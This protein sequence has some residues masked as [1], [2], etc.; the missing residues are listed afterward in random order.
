MLE[1]IVKLIRMNVIQVRAGTWRSAQPKAHPSDQM[2]SNVLASPVTKVN[3]VE[4]ILTSVNLPLVII[5]AHAHQVL[6]R[7]LVSVYLD[8]LKV[9]SASRKLTSAHLCR[10]N[11]L[12]RAMTSLTSLSVSVRLD[13]AEIDVKLIW[14]SVPIS[15]VRTEQHAPI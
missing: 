9:A 11:I 4:T 7:S 10:V 1:G 14:M 15:R 3:S 8:M 5:M 12:A 6:I 13:T 2:R